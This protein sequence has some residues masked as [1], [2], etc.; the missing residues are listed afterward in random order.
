MSTK[1]SLVEQNGTNKEMREKGGKRG[2]NNRLK[3]KRY[4][5]LMYRHRKFGTSKCDIITLSVLE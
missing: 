4:G 2:G 1:D 5:L 3:K